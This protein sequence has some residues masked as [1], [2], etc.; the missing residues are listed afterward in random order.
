MYDYD[1]FTVRQMLGVDPTSSDDLFT[2]PPAMI[3]VN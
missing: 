3:I 2:R 1:V